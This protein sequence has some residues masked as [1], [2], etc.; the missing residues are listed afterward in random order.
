MATNEE[1]ELASEACHA[2]IRSHSHG[3]GFVSN[4]VKS[5]ALLDNLKHLRAA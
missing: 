1:N 3:L 4:F 5:R 2:R